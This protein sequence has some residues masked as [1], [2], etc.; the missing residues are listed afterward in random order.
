MRILRYKDLAQ[1][2]EH[3]EWLIDGLL[4]NT[5]WTVLTAPQGT[6]K[7]RLMLQMCDALERGVKFLDH[8]ATLK[9]KC[10]FVQIDSTPAEWREIVRQVVPHSSGITIFDVPTFW[11][12]TARHVEWFT[13]TIRQVKPGFI[14][15]DS[16]YK[17]SSDINMPQAIG[18][19]I[20]QLKAMVRLP[21]PQ[22]EV[23]TPWIVLHHPPQGSETRAAGSR[24]IVADA[25][26]TWELSGTQLS[27]TKGRLREKGSFAI[28][29]DKKGLWHMYGD[30]TAWDAGLDALIHDPLL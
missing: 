10:V 12:E 19:R 22:G 21:T 14:V 5:G 1:E 26:Y 4:P 18:P 3:V 11:L 29:M 30:T 2:D 24:S 17:I 16:L 23:D 9:T 15:F 8:F 28:E 27:V 13:D 7:T 20:A 25:S 6:G